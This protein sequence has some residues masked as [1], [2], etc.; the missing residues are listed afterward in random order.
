[1]DADW[2]RIAD[3]SSAPVQ[4]QIVGQNLAYTIYTSGSTGTPKGVQVTHRAVTNFL[5][6]LARKPGLQPHDVLLA[7]TTLSF[8]IAGLELFLPLVVGARLAIATREEARSG[9]ALLHR[10]DGR[11]VTGLQATPSTWRLLIEAGWP[12]D[13]R[14]PLKVLCGGEALPSDLA[15]QL[16]Q[17]SSQ[18]WNMY[19]PTETTIWS[20]CWRVPISPKAVLIGRPLANTTC[21]VLDP[22]VNVA[23]IGVAGELCIGGGGVARG[24]LHRPGMT[25]ELFIPDPFTPDSGM[26]MYRTGDL[27]RRL[28]DGNLEFLGRADQ[29]VK[30]RGLRIELGEI[31]S[32]LRAH[33]LVRDAVVLVREDMPGDKRLSAYVTATDAVS[34]PTIDALRAHLTTRIP[35]YMVPS[36]WVVLDALP[37]TPNGKVDRKAL[38]AP[39]LA[40]AAAA[41]V[42]PRNALEEQLCAVFAE[43][44][45]LPQVGVDD[46]FFALGGHSLMVMQLLNRIRLAIGIEMSV[47][48]VFECPTVALLARG[49]GSSESTHEW[50]V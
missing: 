21:Y 7:V 1:M 38:P 4:A 23:P 33:A 36:S 19:G 9:G 43:V 13:K 17:S 11:G 50:S 44:L 35:E 10:I 29:Q 16:T 8:D 48:T 6:S 40:S 37:L 2:E 28:P 12:G 24:Y 22:S 25:A 14:A 3:H 20:T 34:P 18:V 30:I 5:T 45:R 27:V 47:R 31:E 32:Q 42:P 15:Y 46:D 26:R 49:A 39:D 41:Y